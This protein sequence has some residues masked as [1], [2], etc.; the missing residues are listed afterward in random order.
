MKIERQFAEVR[1]SS[2]DRQVKFIFS[3]DSKDRHGTRIAPE[4][5]RLDNFN[6]NGIASFQHRAYG[7]PDP[8]MIIGKAQAWKSDGRLVGTIDFETKEVNALADKLYKKVQAGTLNAVSVGFV[9]HNGHWG[10]DEERGHPEEESD[11]YYFDDIELMEISLVTVPSNPEALALRSFESTEK[12]WD[13]M[14]KA[15]QGV[16]F[17][18]EEKELTGVLSRTSMPEFKEQTQTDLTEQVTKS[19]KMEV[20]KE[21]DLPETSKVEHEVKLDTEGL[22]E[23]IVDGVKEGIKEAMPPEALPGA[24][25]QDVSDKD[26]KSLDKYSIR[27]AI[28]KK[29]QA[30]N[31]EGKLDGIEGEMHQEAIREAKGTGREISG[32]GIPLMY[33]NHRATLQATTDAAGGYTVAEDTVSFIDSLKNTMATISAGATFMSGLV[34]DVKIPRLATDSVATWR[35]EGGVATQSDPTFEGPTLVPHRLTAYTVYSMQLLRQS[36]LDI[37][38]IVSDTLSY[39]IANALEAAA[40]EGDGTSQVPVGI[41]NASNVNDAHHGSTSTLA[42]WTNI[43]NMEKMVAADNALAAKMAYIMTT[44]A[45]AQLKITSADS[46]GGGYIWM[47]DPILGG[48]VNGYRAL[49]TNVLT[50]A[51]VLYGNWAELMFGQWG[52]IDL[53]INP[54]S[55]DTYAEVRVVIAGYFDVQLKHGQSFAKI[56]VLKGA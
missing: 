52:G 41:L 48:T 19:N 17:R 15:V 18:I 29:A 27:K 24:P 55:R 6:K 34:G 45:A 40:L 49:T 35:T 8:D 31:G 30:Q 12:D 9:E 56:D 14:T 39:S 11:T 16:E 3:T 13:S 50:N 42:S 7:D 26:K 33:L 20:K 5:W 22:K 43:V 38:K 32:P 10:Q 4:G 53:L 47:Q 23:A 54:Y 28:L 25:A 21:N 46:V 51:S 37:D 1:A 2:E 44:S 36:T